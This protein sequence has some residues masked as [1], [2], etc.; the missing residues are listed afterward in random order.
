MPAGREVGPWLRGWV[1]DDEPQTIVVW[2]QYL[3]LRFPAHGGNV[4][5][6]AEAGGPGVLRGGGAADGGTP[7]DRNPARG[8][9]AQ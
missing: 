2:R 9:V 7:G 5:A 3:P 6:Q 1:E 4:E 8:R